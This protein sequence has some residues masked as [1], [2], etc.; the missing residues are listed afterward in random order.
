MTTDVDSR[1]MDNALVRVSR[2]LQSE[3][4]DHT[5]SVVSIQLAPYEDEADAVVS[6][7]LY[8]NT[9]CRIGVL[10]H[11]ENIREA[12]PAVR[13]HIY[14][15]LANHFGGSVNEDTFEFTGSGPAGNVVAACLRRHVVFQYQRVCDLPPLP[16]ATRTEHVDDIVQRITSYKA[17]AIRWIYLATEVNSQFNSASLHVGIVRRDGTSVQQIDA[18]HDVNKNAVAKETCNYVIRALASSHDRIDYN[19]KM[20]EFLE[21]MPVTE[22]LSRLGRSPSSSWTSMFVQAVLSAVQSASVGHP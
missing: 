11:H 5:S 15:V 4:E 16:A 1:Y 3:L 6:Y 7:V 8:R 10:F 19:G 2:H 22:V 17:R 18:Y 9:K 13:E 14:G 21:P 12:A 20:L